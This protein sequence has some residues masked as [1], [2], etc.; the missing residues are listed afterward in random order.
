MVYNCFWDFVF[1]HSKIILASLYPSSETPNRFKCNYPCIN[2]FI[3]NNST[4]SDPED[5]PYL[6]LDVF[7]DVSS[8]IFTSYQR[9][10]IV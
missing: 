4:P 6:N 9:I 7:E 1:S 10:L 3:T 8:D 2:S 5:S